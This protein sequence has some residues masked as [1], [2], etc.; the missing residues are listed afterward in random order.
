MRDVVIMYRKR[1]AAKMPDNQYTRELVQIFDKILRL[2]KRPGGDDGGFYETE[3]PEKIIYLL[4]LANPTMFEF[5]PV[6]LN[7]AGKYVIRKGWTEGYKPRMY[8]RKVLSFLGIPTVTLGAF[9][10]K[11]GG[12][13]ISLGNDH[14]RTDVVRTMNGKSSYS[15]RVKSHEEVK[16][17]TKSR[18]PVILVDIGGSDDWKEKT[19]KSKPGYYYFG[20][21]YRSLPHEIKFGNSRYILDTITLQNNNAGDQVTTK[22]GVKTV[23]SHAIAGVTCNGQRYIYSGWVRKTKDSARSNKINN[24]NNTNVGNTPCPLM[25]FDWTVDRRSFYITSKICH[26]QFTPPQPNSV[27]FNSMSG[28]RQFYYVRSDLVKY[29]TRMLQRLR[30]VSGKN[31]ILLGKNIILRTVSNARTKSVRMNYPKLPVRKNPRA[32]MSKRRR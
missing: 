6:R 9:K 19:G 4:N 11:E 17:L 24:D 1:W 28:T 22:S 2:Y 23:G 8:A 5:K 21:K 13:S 27:R 3:T 16:A 32:K 12:L 29:K 30:V 15:Y 18:P 20:G 14:S 10:L 25:P 31:K 7:S 26:A